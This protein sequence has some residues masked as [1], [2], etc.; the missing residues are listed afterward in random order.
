M[1]VYLK[2]I[3]VLGSVIMGFCKN[4]NVTL[5]MSRDLNSMSRNLNFHVVRPYLQYML[6]SSQSG[7]QSPPHSTL[8]CLLFECSQDLDRQ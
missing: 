6:A 4:W 3:A 2:E 7:R 5:T 8:Y 1:R